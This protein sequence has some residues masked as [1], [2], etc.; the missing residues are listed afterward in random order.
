MCVCVRV[1]AVCARA[2]VVVGS[3]C[4][5][6]KEIMLHRIHQT[7]TLNA[8]LFHGTVLV[9][10]LLFCD[11]RRVQTKPEGTETAGKK[12]GKCSLFGATGIIRKHVRAWLWLWLRDSRQEAVWVAHTFI[13]RMTDDRGPALC[14]PSFGL[15]LNF[16]SCE[17]CTVPTS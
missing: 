11:M 2:C 1:R 15:L 13:L 5:T 3:M 9:L 12:C 17:A 14:L 7:L 16:F 4:K 10:L 6:A 8:Y